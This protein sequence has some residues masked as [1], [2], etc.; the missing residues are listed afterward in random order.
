MTMR[1]LLTNKK[2]WQFGL[3]VDAL[4]CVEIALLVSFIK[5]PRLAMNFAPGWPMA[6]IGAFF[7]SYVLA[8]VIALIGIIITIWL[9]KVWMI[10]PQGPPPA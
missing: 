4:I 9:L 2:F 5:V 1:Q 3:L 7:Q 10:K 8:F 6:W